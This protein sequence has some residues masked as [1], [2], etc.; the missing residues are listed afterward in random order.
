[1]KKRNSTNMCMNIL[2]QQPKLCITSSVPRPNNVQ[3]HTKS[4]FKSGTREGNAFWNR[5]H[6]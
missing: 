1:M 4:C 3:C 5:G 6:K 2:P